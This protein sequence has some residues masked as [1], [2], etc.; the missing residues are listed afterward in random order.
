MPVPR[1]PGVNLPPN[2]P[3][4]YP[5]VA[6]RNVKYNEL[7]TLN[8]REGDGGIIKSTQDRRG[9]VY[10]LVG[11]PRERDSEGQMPQGYV[12]L[13]D[14]TIGHQRTYGDTYWNLQFPT[15]SGIIGPRNM[16]WTKME[17]VIADILIALDDLCKTKEGETRDFLPEWL[18]AMINTREKIRA[19]VDDIQQGATRAQMHATMTQDNLTITE[20]RDAGT[21][22]DEDVI[23]SG[24][25]TIIYWDWENDPDNERQPEQYCGQSVNMVSRNA[26]HEAAKDDPRFSHIAH[27]ASSRHANERKMFP[28]YLTSNPNRE[29]LTLIEQMLILL[30]QSYHPYIT[31]PV[32]RSSG[33]DA[34]A[35]MAIRSTERHVFFQQ[36]ACFLMTIARP[37][38]A[39][40]GW[41][42][43]SWN[44]AYGAGKGLNWSSPFM[45]DRFGVRALYLRVT[46]PNVLTSFRR[47]PFIVGKFEMYK[48]LHEGTGASKAMVYKK[49]G[50]ISVKHLSP[51]GN[52]EYSDY[53]NF[54]DDIEAPGPELGQECQLI[55]ELMED[56]RRHSVPWCRIPDHFP[57][58]KRNEALS[59]GIRVEWQ[60]DGAW[61]TKYIQSTY[62]QNYPRG[63]VVSTKKGEV[64]FYASYHNAMGLIRYLKGQKIPAGQRETANKD[65]GIARVQSLRFD[66]LTQTFVLTEFQ[67]PRAHVSDRKKSKVQMRNELNGLN[68]VQQI[69][70]SVPNGF[71][72]RKTC[73]RCYVLVQ[74][75]AS[76]FKCV[77]T[78][79][80]DMC[81]AEIEEAKTPQDIVY[82]NV[83]IVQGVLSSGH[84]VD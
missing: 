42:A 66:N 33:S 78:N 2:W 57:Y 52:V 26:S 72:R 11:L 9:D 48:S 69:G 73:D 38:F 71:G 51:S 68:G 30:F 81:E 8:L 45:E 27:Y 19:L 12:R 80:P 47:Q 22:L 40:H 23:D 4:G 76:E 18:P 65:F 61:K 24:V 83:A 62:M 35:A 36:M 13:R 1:P 10:L 20:L 54:F 63:A 25:Y 7:D 43:G 82:G 29:K 53:L 6:K 5:F 3:S 74:R 67:Q 37:V 39:R 21:S 32:K 44:P 14:V 70:G 79:D 84:Q 41:T 60:R 77:P 15:S 46:I 16:A 55:F 59:L 34:D 75:M 17:N 58:E 49:Y 31:A 64:Q 50:S 28:L 56:G